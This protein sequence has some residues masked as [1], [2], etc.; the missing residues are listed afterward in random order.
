MPAIWL[1]L[2]AQLGLSVFIDELT[3]P[4]IQASIGKGKSD[5]LIYTGSTEQNGPHMV[6][7]KHNFIAHYAAGKIAARLGTALVYPVLPFAP[8]G[9]VEPKSGHMRFPGSVTVS[10]STYG[11][12][13]RDVAISALTAGF[14]RVF[15]MGDHGGGQGVLK[16][17]AADLDARFKSRGLRVYYVPDVYY[18]ADEQANAELARRGIKSGTHAGPV[19]TSELM[20]IDAESRW[21]RRDRLAASD[22]AK[23]PETGVNGDPTKAS[24]AL[25]R[26]LL[27][28]KIAAAVDQIHRLSA[29]ARP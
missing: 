27:E 18:K 28:Q 17:V 15:L 24:A 12:V 25:G 16:A 26:I 8:T 5:A 20:A 22:S 11:A 3:W 7:G 9:N 4:E 6:L 14:K 21:V 10:D 2:L 1:F 19:D 23:E 29:T 13:V